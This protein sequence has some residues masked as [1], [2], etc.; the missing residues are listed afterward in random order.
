MEKKLTLID[1]FGLGLLTAF[2]AL[3][4]AP[5]I[6]GIP[7]LLFKIDFSGLLSLGFLAI[8]ISLLDI[9]GFVVLAF[10]L[11]GFITGDKYL[12]KVFDP[13]FKLFSFLLDESNRR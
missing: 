4:S 11:L 1:R 2:V 10:F 13:L 5:F 6:L 7:L 12:S 8:S 3:F 9:L